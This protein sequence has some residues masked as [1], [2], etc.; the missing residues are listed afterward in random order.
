MYCTKITEPL[1]DEKKPIS[2]FTC[3]WPD[4]PFDKFLMILWLNSQMRNDKKNMDT[5]DQLLFYVSLQDRY[6]TWTA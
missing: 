6:T 1:P 2:D 3:T 4:Y 5:T